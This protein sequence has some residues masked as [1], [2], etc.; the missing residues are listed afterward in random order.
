MKMFL[1]VFQLISQTEVTQAYAFYTVQIVIVYV[2]QAKETE[3][4]FFSPGQIRL[5]R[6]LISGKHHNVSIHP[7]LISHQTYPL[8]A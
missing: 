5:R 8:K 3:E 6:A 2:M 1:I 4:Q 7:K